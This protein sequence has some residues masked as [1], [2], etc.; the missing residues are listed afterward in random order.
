M[1]R[2]LTMRIRGAVIAVG[3]FA[4]VACSTAGDRS[5]VTTLNSATTTTPAVVAH[6]DGAGRAPLRVSDGSSFA[7][8]LAKSGVQCTW[9]DHAG[10]NLGTTDEG[11]CLGDNVDLRVTF[12][13]TS[14]DLDSFIAL[15]QSI[16]CSSSTRRSEVA[17]RGDTWLAEGDTA[18]SIASLARAT[19]WPTITFSC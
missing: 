3:A 13:A 1:A 19:G 18:A 2:L 11:Y 15:A 14:A 6:G 5:S 12:T 16:G 9:D 17:I 7:A 10:D 8:A 4:L